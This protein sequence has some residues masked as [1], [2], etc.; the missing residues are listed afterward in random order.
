MSTALKAAE[1]EATRKA[2]E[3]KQR[4]EN[5]TQKRAAQE[6]EK[7]WK[8]EERRS[9]KEE[10]ERK[11]EIGAIEEQALEKEETCIRMVR[12]SAKETILGEKGNKETKAEVG[13]PAKARRGLRNRKN[14][15]AQ[16]F[17]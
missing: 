13:G 14:M 16:C 11:E 17:G 15:S 12:R 10:Q 3:A 5:A 1:E 9:K 2:E 4:K 6:M 7:A 8:Q